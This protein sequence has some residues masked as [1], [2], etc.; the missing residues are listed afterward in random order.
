[1]QSSALFILM[2]RRPPRAAL[3]PYTTLFRSSRRR[4]TRLVSHCPISYAVF[5]LKKKKPTIEAQCL[6]HLVVRLL[7]II[8]RALGRFL[9]SWQQHTVCWIQRAQSLAPDDYFAVKCMF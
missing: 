8:D 2:K 6:T 9:D 5:C 4:H 7:V 1:M 3:F